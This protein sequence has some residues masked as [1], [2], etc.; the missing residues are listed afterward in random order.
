MG[1]IPALL[2]PQ[3][4]REDPKAM[5]QLVEKYELHFLTA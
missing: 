1:L 2:L 3:A 5:E 4:D